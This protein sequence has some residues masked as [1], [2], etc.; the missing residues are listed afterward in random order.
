VTGPSAKQ[1]LKLG[2]PIEDKDEETT[3]TS[4]QVVMNFFD[5]P[6]YKN[7]VCTLLEGAVLPKREVEEFEIYHVDRRFF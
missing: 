3:V 5:H 4:N 1:A 7:H 2:K 6:V